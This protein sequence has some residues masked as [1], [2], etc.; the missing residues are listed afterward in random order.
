MRISAPLTAH[1]YTGFLANAVYCALTHRYFSSFLL[2]I[3]FFSVVATAS[4]HIRLTG[5]LSGMQ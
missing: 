1:T 4:A 5:L 2:D 3:F